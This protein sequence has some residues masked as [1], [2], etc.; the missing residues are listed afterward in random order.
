MRFIKCPDSSRGTVDLTK[1]LITEL[2]AGKRV[3]WFVT[4]GSNIPAAVEIMEHIPRPLTNLL[5]I[6]LTDERYGEPGHDDSNWQQLMAVGFQ[7]K[8]A[9]LLPILISGASLEEVTARFDEL[10]TKQIAESD[11]VVGLFG[12]GTDG[13]IAG[14][15]PDTK[16]TKARGLAVGY[17][18][19]QF[20]RVSIT[21]AAFEQLNAAYVFAFS[22]AKTAAL[23]A[24][25]EKRS[26][27]EQ[28]AQILKRIP[29]AYVYND[30]VGE[31]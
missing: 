23:A 31:S 11:V 14:I 27:T 5:S 29:E 30:S 12:M 28:P 7:G 4:G 8:E 13:H 6:T 3:L 19:E 22:S 24:L 2:T 10:L 1:R 21:F 9:V 20:A 18:T 26:L 25:A 15:L 17:E 16:A